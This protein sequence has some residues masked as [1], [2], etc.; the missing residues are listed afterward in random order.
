MAAE[1]RGATPKDFVAV[2]A[3]KSD[4]TYLRFMYVSAASGARDANGVL[5]KARKTHESAGIVT[6]VAGLVR[7]VLSWCDFCKDFKPRISSIT[8]VA[9]GSHLSIRIGNDLLNAST[10]DNHKDT[11]ARLH[12]FLGDY[13]RVEFYACKTGKDDDANSGVF[14]RKVSGLLKN[15]NVQGYESNQNLRVFTRGNFV[16]NLVQCTRR[17]CVTDTGEPP[18]QERRGD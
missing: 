11:L 4:P 17:I 3:K 2:G 10:I 15:I 1:P 13:S 6:T 18:P 16:G 8:I 12:P 14:L 7:D 9:H 5:D